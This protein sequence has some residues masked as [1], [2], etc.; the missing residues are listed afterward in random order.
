MPIPILPRAAFNGV[1]FPVERVR[2]QGGIRDHVHEYPHVPGGDPEKLG[3]RLYEIEMDANFQAEAK[4]YPNLWPG[5]LAQLRVFFE[6]EE[7]APLVIPTIGSIDAYCVN[8]SQELNA[9]MLTGERATF[10]F[11]EDQESAFLINRL[12]SIKVESL[13]AR[14][15]KF[16]AE[17]TRYG[18]PKNPIDEI[19]N[20]VNTVL[21]VVDTA[22][23][24][25]QLLANK[26][27]L[28]TALCKEF[29][30]RVDA[31]NNP[32]AW[33][34]LEALKE[35]W[36]AAV[37][38]SENVTGAETMFGTYEVPVLMTAPQVSQAI[39]R[40]TSRAMEILQ[41]N[42]IEDAYAIQRGTRLRYVIEAA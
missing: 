32:T 17:A 40:T 6:A 41:L 29:D 19:V 27:G 31:F 20:A 33:P 12:V 14:S 37:Q 1:E 22:D 8:W 7:T 5:R 25:G 13:G 15:D 4:A 39:Y 10:M 9:R 35:L 16:E 2:V 34:A 18:L 42:P 26:I 3:R 30:Q 21:A 28:L 23:A 38:L 11:R 36:A 24:F